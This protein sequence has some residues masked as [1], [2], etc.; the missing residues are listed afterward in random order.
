[1]TIAGRTTHTVKVDGTERS[2][3]G[4]TEIA[5][6]FPD[7]LM[8]K[9]K[10]GHVGGTGERTVSRHQ[11]IVIAKTGTGEGVK[12]LLE[13]H[14]VDIVTDDGKK[15]TI[16][17]QA[18]GDAAFTTEDG[19]KVIVRKMESGAEGDLKIRIGD[20]AADEKHFIMERH[21]ARR[22]PRRN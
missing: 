22:G 6:Q 18:G 21:A 12:P 2:E 20:P 10:T 5:L 16:K 19:K 13:D 11:E 15:F 9:F 1:M 7:Q 3:Q 14:D 8:R 17:K 4:E